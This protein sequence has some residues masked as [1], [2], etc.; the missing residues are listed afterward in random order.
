MTEEMSLADALATASSIMWA[1]YKENFDES[2]FASIHVE[3]A[4]SRTEEEIT[5]LNRKES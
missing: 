4:I 5:N 3:K 2:D 1:W